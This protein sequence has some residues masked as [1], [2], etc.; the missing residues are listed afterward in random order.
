[1]INKFAFWWRSFRPHTLSASISPIFV[2][3][4]YAIF[5]QRHFY[6]YIALLMLSSTVLIQIATNLFNEYFDYKSGLDNKDSIGNG[7][8]ILIEGT[9]PHL[10]FITAII[11]YCIAG[12][13]GI[14][15]SWLTSW[16]LII[17]G[18]MCMLC[19]YLYNGGFYPISRSPLGELFAGG[20][21][22]TGLVLISFYIQTGYVNLNVLFISLPMFIL[23]SLILTANNLRDRKNDEINGRRTLVILLGHH[24]SY[25]LILFALILAYF[26]LL[27][28]LIHHHWI[29]LLPILS[30]KY[31]STILSS[32]RQESFS[33]KQMMPGMIAISKIN[34]YYGCLLSLGFLIECF[35]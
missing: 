1:M 23:I 3:T 11:F 30:I 26:W 9:S 14:I 29:I 31:L 6:I 33:P 17:I 7:G 19:G 20:L 21:M 2:G 16:N 10:V 25:L 35:L 15:L 5:V 4:S 13:L 8:I 24:Q 18:A 22:G 12:L 27:L 32:L 28:L 34:W